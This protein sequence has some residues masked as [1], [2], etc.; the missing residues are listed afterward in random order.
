M[1]D[2]DAIEEKEIR[3]QA[4]LYRIMKNYANEGF[5]I[6]ESF[7]YE[8]KLDD[9]LIEASINLPSG[10]TKEADLILM[11]LGPQYGETVRKP[12]LVIETKVRKLSNLTKYY[13]KAL[14]QARVYAHAIGC[15][16]YAVYDGFTLL[17]M[18]IAK[19]FLIGLTQWTQTRNDRRNRDFARKLWRTA[20]DLHINI[21][22]GPVSEFV[23]HSDFSP[24]KRSVYYF[25]R[26]AFLFK[27][28]VDQGMSREQFEIER[29]SKLL[30]QKWRELYR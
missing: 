26:D 2:E 18:Q 16:A 17:L 30:A 12:I 20:I 23:Y 22:S 3:I 28:E 7:T 4:D 15:K 14:N 25:I 13:Q 19:P 9:V 27:V 11:G 10:V 24:W 6:A 21:A 5:S 29:D 1:L 8:W